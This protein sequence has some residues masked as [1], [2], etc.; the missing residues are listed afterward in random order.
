MNETYK[1]IHAQRIAKDYT[2]SILE[3]AKSERKTFFVM[4][5]QT[6]R[7]LILQN[8]TLTQSQTEFVTQEE[9]LLEF[10]KAF[11]HMR[12]V[13]VKEERNPYFITQ[14]AGILLDWS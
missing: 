13:S 12:V 4:Q 6:V 2:E 1:R 5:P 14:Q 10:Q 9:V 7:L 3:V 8:N 11:P